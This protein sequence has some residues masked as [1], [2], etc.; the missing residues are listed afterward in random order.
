M[1]LGKL[2]ELPKVAVKATKL[3]LFKDSESEFT[4]NLM[5]LT[6][7]MLTISRLTVVITGCQIDLT[8]NIY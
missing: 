6:I 3:N 5:T 4:I 1:Y 8:S 7:Y 2:T